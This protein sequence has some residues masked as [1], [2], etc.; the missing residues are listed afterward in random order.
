MEKLGMVNIAP[1]LLMEMRKGTEKRPY[2]DTKAMQQVAEHMQLKPT[3]GA[4]FLA[5]DSSASL[6]SKNMHTTN[7]QES[8]C[9]VTSEMVEANLSRACQ[10]FC[11]LCMTLSEMSPENAIS[12]ESTF[13]DNVMETGT[14]GSNKSEEL[15]RLY[16]E[17]RASNFCLCACINKVKQLALFDRPQ[18]GTP[19]PSGSDAPPPPPQ[20]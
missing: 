11:C 7:G 10:E 19:L 15:K 9:S 5:I 17:T 20:A 16:Q 8:I 18:T 1:E 13:V 2:F 4:K 6:L 3:D 14:F 12:E